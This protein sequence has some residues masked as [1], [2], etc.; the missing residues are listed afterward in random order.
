[1][2]F[3][4]STVYQE[5]PT[6]YTYLPYPLPYL[7]YPLSYQGTFFVMFVIGGCVTMTPPRE[8]VIKHHTDSVM[9]WVLRVCYGSPLTIDAN[10]H[11]HLMYDVTVTSQPMSC[12]N[13]KNRQNT[14][15]R[16]FCDH[17]VYLRG[18]DRC[19][20]RPTSRHVFHQNK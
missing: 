2:T 9:N 15:F 18:C 20:S 8:F 1:M 16:N 7:P 10:K 19:E 3:F 6:Y 5:D 14:G 13:S 17:N 4:C 12:E 11:Q